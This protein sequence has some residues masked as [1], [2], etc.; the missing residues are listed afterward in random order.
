MNIPAYIIGEDNIVRK[1]IKEPNGYCESRDCYF[2]NLSDY[3]NLSYVWN[4]DDNGLSNSLVSNNNAVIRP[5][6]SISKDAIVTGN[7]TIGNPFVI[8]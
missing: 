1:N 4:V 6:I 8:Q 2:Y 3:D 7:G 5:V